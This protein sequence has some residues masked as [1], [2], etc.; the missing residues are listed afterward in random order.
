MPPTKK[1][2]NLARDFMI[3]FGVAAVLMN[4]HHASQEPSHRVVLW[5]NTT[6]LVNAPLDPLSAALWLARQP[7]SCCR[8]AKPLSIVEG[9]EMR[10]PALLL[11]WVFAAVLAASKSRLL[12]K[13]VT[14][15]PLLHLIEQK[16]FL[17]VC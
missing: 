4:N 3:V 2:L 1:K 16:I 12:T 9:D 14:F 10:R 17:H 15:H 5:R 7:T 11:P 13:P 8:R 6:A